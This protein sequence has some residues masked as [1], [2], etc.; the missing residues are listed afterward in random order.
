MAFRYAFTWGFFAL[1]PASVVGAILGFLM[2]APPT[3]FGS[4]PDAEGRPFSMPGAGDPAFW[5]WFMIGFIVIEL[6]G[7]VAGIVAGSKAEK[8]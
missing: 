8:K 7:I 6:A 2:G 4:G 3:S 1:I 5:Q